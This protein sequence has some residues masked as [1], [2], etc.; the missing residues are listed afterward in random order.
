MRVTVENKQG[1][2]SSLTYILNYCYNTLL[3]CLEPPQLQ[4]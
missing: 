1:I 4:Q 2:R 3:M